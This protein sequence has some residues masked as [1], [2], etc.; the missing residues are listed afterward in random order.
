MLKKSAAL[1]TCLML[2]LSLLVGCSGSDN[3]AGTAGNE[4][5]EINVL[6]A[7][8]RLD[9]MVDGWEEMITKFEEEN[10]GVNVNLEM[11][12]WEAIPQYLAQA[13]MA[14]EQIDIIRTTG[15]QIRSTLAPAGALMELSEVVEPIKDRFEEGTLDVYNVGGYQWGIPYSETTVS[16]VYYNK[17]MFDEL[18][19]EEPKTLDELQ[20]CADVIR[21]EKGIAN[22]WIHQGAILGYWQ[23]FFE[24]TYAQTSHNESIAKAEDWLSGNSSFVNDETIEAFAMIGELFERGILTKDSLNTDDTG[25][26]A[27]FAQQEAAMFYG[28]TWEYA[29]V[30]EIVGDT[31]EVG[32]FM[33]PEMADGLVPQGSGAA[34][35][36]IAVASNCNK[37]HA[38]MVV[39]FLEFMT[40]PENAQLT[41]GATE[42]I[43]PVIKG[44][45]AVD[46]PCAEEL[47][48]FVPQN[49]MYIDWMLPA[50]INDALG[51]AIAGV[52]SGEV[53][54]EQAAQSVQDAYETVVREKDYSYD[55][56]NDWTEEQWA[57]V[58][59][60]AG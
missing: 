43:L 1:I 17:T 37:E 23:M 33:F 27:L 16:C 22:P 13:R 11:Q 55:W 2:A 28:G 18:G 29:P 21:E 12:E 10:P 25:M 53:T 50:E 26:K 34:D 24:E 40:R 57:A 49:I 56:Y 20:H 15:G 7:T 45:E 14:G 46:M 41:I 51:N 30:L 35:D 3:A 32:V 54:P 39:K 5:I 9:A 59:L 6:S 60:K 58:E 8:M 36:G 47:M 4:E 52:A 42:P 19:L 31:F 38:D 44:V 48:S